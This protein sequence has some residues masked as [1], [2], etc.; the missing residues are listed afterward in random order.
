MLDKE[1][2]FSLYYEA[3]WAI[4]QNYNMENDAKTLCNNLDGY[5]LDEDNNKFQ[6]NYGQICV[7]VTKIPGSIPKVSDVFEYWVDNGFYLVDIRI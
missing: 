5:N 7:T 1:K 2:A 3:F 6:L 4:H